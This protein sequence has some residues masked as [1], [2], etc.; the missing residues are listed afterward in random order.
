MSILRE[1]I[2]RLRAIPAEWKAH[3]DPLAELRKIRYGYDPEEASMA[4]QLT[5]TFPMTQ[6]EYDS[7]VQKLIA[8]GQTVPGK[9][10]KAGNELDYSYDPVAGTVTLVTVHE[11]WL[12]PAA[13]LAKVDEMLAEQGVTVTAQGGQA[14]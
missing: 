1:D 6:A 9:V 4:E 2:E 5:Q 11:F 3:P 7:L 12:S 13:L 14:Q 8:A 10:T